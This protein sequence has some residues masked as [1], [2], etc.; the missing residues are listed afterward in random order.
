MDLSAWKGGAIFRHAIAPVVV[1][2]AATAALAASELADGSAN[3][4]PGTPEFS[5]ILS[6]Y[7]TR[8]EWKVAGVDYYVG[9]PSGAALKDPSTL[10]MAGVS[11]DKSTHVISVSGSNVTL[12]GYDF[13]LNG[14]WQVDV[15]NGASNVTV[16]NSNFHV[17]ANN[18]T[19]IYAYYG[20][21]LNVR[22]NTFDG[23]A[24]GGSTVH[25]MVFTGNG[26]AT[27]EYNRFS[28]FPD[29]AIDITYDGNYVVQYNLFDSMGAG[30]F[31]TD[32]I[33]TY[34]SDIS[35]LL[36]QYNTMY[37]PPSMPKGVIN[38]FVRIGD[39]RGHVVHDPVAA[40]NTI[41]MAST[42]AKT[43]NVLQWCSDGAAT[44]VNPLIHDNYV[45]PTGVMYAINSPYILD[46]TGVVGPVTYSNRD[47]KTG[48][49]ALFGPYNS[50]FVGP[51]KP[52]PIPVITGVG[53]EGSKGGALSGTSVAGARIDVY[54]RGNLLG[55]VKADAEGRWTFSMAEAADGQQIFSARAT[56]AYANSSLPSAGV[57]PGK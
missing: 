1:A 3:A 33:Q 40:Y 7:A 11:V 12:D 56:D 53:G 27:I 39:Q 19:P 22:N 54:D 17:G 26:G 23:Y 46:P 57:S 42:N 45:D 50:R 13:A 35:R 15:V 48:R 38:S 2:L 18:L 9:T 55:A 52:P 37:Q 5:N 8:P 32:S 31:H 29:D 43:A 21:T 24:S 36:I 41:I 49:L 51:T 47:L 14:G 30:E 20:G 10:S 28:N 44:L 34:F 6:G 25:S 4:P 16:Q